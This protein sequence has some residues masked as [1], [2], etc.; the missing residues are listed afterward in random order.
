MFPIHRQTP[1]QRF[2][3]NTG[4]PMQFLL[5]MAKSLQR[6]LSSNISTKPSSRVEFSHRESIYTR[7][8]VP[9]RCSRRSTRLLL[10]CWIGISRSH[11]RSRQDRPDSQQQQSLP[12][13]RPLQQRPLPFPLSTQTRSSPASCQDWNHRAPQSKASSHFFRPKSRLEVV[14]AAAVVAG[15]EKSPSTVGRTGASAMPPTSA[16]ILWPA[17]R[18]LPRITIRWRVESLMCRGCC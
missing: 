3:G 8:L 6:R 14:A 5:P 15:R 1:F 16:Y 2:L 17:P 7:S 9:T 18:P 4:K 13:Q 11:C 12:T 10:Y